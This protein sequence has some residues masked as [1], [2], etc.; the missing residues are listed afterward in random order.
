MIIKRIL[1]AGLLLT[2]LCAGAQTYVL[3]T[4]SHAVL[5]ASEVENSEGWRTVFQ[6]NGADNA[7]TLLSTNSIISGQWVHNNGYYGAPGGAITGTFTDHP[8]SLMTGHISRMTIGT[9]GNIG[10]GTTTPEQKLSVHGN[11]FSSVHSAEGGALILENSTKTALNTAYR[12]ALYNMTGAYG[13]GLQF[14]NYGQDGSYGS[15]F[16]ISDTGNVGVGTA[17]PTEKL[18]VSG[19]I[20]SSVHS[21]E[22]AGLILENSTKTMGNTAY[23]WAFYNM[24]GTYGN[25]LQF[26]NYSLDG[27]SYGPRLTIS[28]TGNVGIGT[29][30]PL[31][32]LSVNGKMRVH[33]VKVETSN[34]P[35]YVFNED[36]RKD[37]LSDIEKFIRQNKH[38]PDIPSAKEAEE[39]GIALGE[40][41][42]LLLKKIEELTLHLI[43]KDKQIKSGDLRMS[44]MEKKIQIIMKGIQGRIKIN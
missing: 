10:V 35:D 42:K 23:R 13:N 31:E 36:Y 16:T 37:S 40:M 30:T 12:W 17:T 43:E 22:G 29:T 8:F 19:N 24:T 21:A 38:L 28:D 9:N 18:S 2:A 4:T 26:W 11:I 7:K 34:W 27:N 3:P 25:G 14:W 20:F 1:L 33:E 32:K 5:G 41:N 39:N 44:E 6:V 15:K